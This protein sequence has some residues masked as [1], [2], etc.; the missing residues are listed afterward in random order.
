MADLEK[1]LVVHDTFLPESESS[2]K[3]WLLNFRNSVHS[4]IKKNSGMDVRCELSL[5]QNIAEDNGLPE[6]FQKY[7][8]FIF[9]VHN[10]IHKNSS[11]TPA[12][13][14]IRD[15]INNSPDFFDQKKLVFVL[16][17]SNLRDQ[18]VINFERAHFI[19]FF[20]QKKDNYTIKT[21]TFDVGDRSYWARIFEISNYI[22]PGQS[23]VQPDA[24]GLKDET[25]VYLARTTRDL[26]DQRDQLK[27]NLEFLGIKVLPE[28]RS[29]APKAGD[30]RNLE[31]LFGKCD[32]F[33]QMMGAEFEKY[34]RR[35]EYADIIQESNTISELIARKSN[36]TMKKHANRII[37][38]PE[39]T[40]FID[41]HKDIF[42]QRIKKVIQFN[43]DYTDLLISSFEQLEKTIFDSLKIRIKHVQK[44]DDPD[45]QDYIYI[46]HE[47]TSVAKVEKLASLFEKH[48]MKTL[49]THELHQKKNFIR[50]HKNSMNNCEAIILYYGLENIHW[51][52]SMVKEIIKA[53]KF[54]RSIPFRFKIIV[55]EERLIQTL[56]N[57]D[58]FI[59]IDIES[60]SN[61]SFFNDHFL[62]MIG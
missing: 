62:K 4:V 48:A 51:F 56:P 19:N 10:N 60:L 31:S 39:D 6:H 53:N 55:G 52:E 34:S 54:H 24:Q 38:I 14:K 25:Y 59:Y 36:D 32:L 5:E 42:I 16:L 57:Y 61:Q 35:P 20:S 8:A 50:A 18:S 45:I 27:E 43:E 41:Y 2:F 49:L 22:F 7:S 28:D 33:I 23:M 15:F 30:S 13:Q 44:S 9:I 47:K 3:K 37:W 29:I 40:L 1:I 12:I 58:D 21:T 11:L 46:L 26:R 17:K